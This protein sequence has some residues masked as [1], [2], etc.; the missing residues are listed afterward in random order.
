MTHEATELELYI[1]NTREIWEGYAEPVIANL[2]RKLDKGDFDRDKSEKAWLN[3]V[4]RAA[5]QYRL[6]H[7]GMTEKWYEVFP[8]G[9]RRRVASN[10][11]DYF[12]TEYNLG[13][14]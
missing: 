14:L 8:M 5:Q 3:V 2:K 10:L 4:N 1:R 6:E 12:M 7:C 9:D 11:A 13:N